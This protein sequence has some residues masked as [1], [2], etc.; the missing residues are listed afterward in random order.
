MPSAMTLGDITVD[1]IARVPYY[2]PLGGDSLAKRA[3]IR[4]GGSAANT[5]IVLRK[6]GLAVGIIA[7]VGEDVLADFALTDLREA[8]LDISYVQRDPK[9]T[10]GLIFAAVTPDGE[11]TFFSCR[12]ANAKT[13]PKLG[14]QRHIRQADVL[15]VSGYAFVDSPQREAALQAIE[16]AHEAGVPV[17][18][19]VSVEVMRTIREE[20]LTMFSR[21]SMVFSNPIP[22]EW[23]TGKSGAEESV[24]ALLSYGPEVVGLKLRDEGCLIGSAAGLERVPG[25]SVDVVD[26]TGAGDSFDAGL[27]LGRL[28]GLS[29]G[30]SGLL[31]NAL[32]GIATTV[33]GGGISLP[34]PKAALSFLRKQRNEAAWQ[35]WSEEPEGVCEFLAQRPDW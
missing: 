19:D 6:F 26:S 21:V 11:R 14:H 13:E 34:G 3:A 2:P 7:R 20:I 28:G 22:A 23:L 35:D 24:E 4:A 31:A 27:I 18:V 29:P 17:T 1:I 10:T 8:G 9:E 5:A 33:V 25:F 32:G 16:V 15:H 12:G 30:E